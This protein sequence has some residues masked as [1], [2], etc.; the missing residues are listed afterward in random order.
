MPY[1]DETKEY[2]VNLIRGARS[3]SIE[4]VNTQKAKGL[5]AIRGICS[6]LFGHGFY[7]ND[8]RVWPHNALMGSM[9]A[10]ARPCPISPKHG[11]VESRRIETFQEFEEIKLET[12]EHDSQAELILMQELTGEFSGILTPTNLSIGWSNDGA[13]SG[14]SKVIPYPDGG[15][16]YIASKHLQKD[17][18]IPSDQVPYIELVEHEGDIKGVQMRAGPKQAQQKDYIPVKC[19]VSAIVRSEQFADNLTGFD[20][21]LRRA[22][23]EC[24]NLNIEDTPHLPCV[25]APDASLASHYAVQA[26]VAGVPCLTTRAPKYAEILEPDSATK[27]V[28]WNT[29]DYRKLGNAVASILTSSGSSRWAAL[30][31]DEAGIVKL[32][33]GALHSHRIWEPEDHLINLMAYGATACAIFT[34]TAALGEIRHWYQSDTGPGSNGTEDSP[35][36]YCSCEDGECEADDMDSPAYCG[37]PLTDIPFYKNGAAK[38]R[39]EVYQEGLRLAIPKLLQQGRFAVDD[40][41]HPGWNGGFGGKGWSMGAQAGIELLEALIEFAETPH[42]DT[43]NKVSTAWNHAVN[44]AHNNGQIMNKWVRGN[45]FDTAALTPGFMFVTKAAVKVV[46][47]NVSHTANADLFYTHS[48]RKIRDGFKKAA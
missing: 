29:T 23:R 32:S 26:M 38:Q 35:C 48:L 46:L 19:Q 33:I 39:D 37:P 12:L 43:W 42:Q 4:E 30:D 18:N 31:D 17:A 9:P 6:S 34:I 21:A 13:T 27:Q 24:N 1:I 41:A 25:Y 11:F 47:S 44:Q 7:V 3:P 16:D 45:L 22:I 36:G 28:K 2:K 14:K 10:F 8:F 20:D 15:F 40:L 5:A